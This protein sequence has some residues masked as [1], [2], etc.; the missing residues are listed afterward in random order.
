MKTHRL[1]G[2]TQCPFHPPRLVPFAAR[3]KPGLCIIDST[4]PSPLLTKTRRRK[5]RYWVGRT[6]VS[7]V[8]DCLEIVGGR[9]AERKLNR[10]VQN[11]GLSLKGRAEIVISLD[12]FRVVSG[13]K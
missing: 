13:T 1:F 2:T 5:V 10:V 11:A 8:T 9:T 4:G 3:A 6:T 7:I 12:A